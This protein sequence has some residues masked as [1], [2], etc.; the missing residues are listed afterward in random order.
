MNITDTVLVQVNEIESL[1]RKSPN[2]AI[3]RAQTEFSKLITSLNDDEVIKFAQ[4]LVEDKKYFSADRLCRVY[5]EKKPKEIRALHLLAT[6]ATRVGQDGV[7]IDYLLDCLD[8]NPNLAFIHFEL[9]NC[10]FNVSNYFMALK[11][12]EVILTSDSDHVDTLGLKAACLIKL[13]KYD[14]AVVVYERLIGLHSNTAQVFLRYGSVLK[15]VGRKEDAIKAFHQALSINENLGEAYW[16]LANLKTYEFDDE[17]INR[18][19]K[20]L[21]NVDEHSQNFVYLN[22]SLAVALEK[23]GEFPSAFQCLEKANKA[24]KIKHNYQAIKTTEKIEKFRN[25]FTREYFSNN[26]SKNTSAEP[27]F[28]LG[29][30]RSGS[31]LI[32][33]VLS[34]HSQIDATMELSEIGAMVRSLGFVKREGYEQGYPDI[35]KS[36]SSDELTNFGNEYLK[37]TKIFR[38]NA[39]HF[40]DKTPSNFIHI[41]LIKSILP[42]AKIIDTRR[43]LMSCGFSIYKQ[44][45]AEGFLFA[46]SLDDIGGYYNDYL[47][48]MDHWHDVLPGEILTVEYENV[49]N[50]LETQVRR[51][52]DFCDL[53]YEE[54]CL[55]FYKS[56]RAVAT[57]SSEQVRQPIYVNALEYW[58]NYEEFLAPLKLFSKT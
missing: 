58:R 51:I 24:L 26:G 9:A 56:K 55:Q 40:I 6:V 10:F 1:A 36:L 23:Q 45:F 31:T 50:D 3:A 46:N 16:N 14:G 39:I 35:L 21:S 19:R 33:Q 22:F 12:C 8:I 43:D 20:L 7:A 25:F 4:Q 11:Q 29:L 47:T 28:I 32:E 15:T 27:I 42:K 13:G 57:I 44:F 17:S 37:R 48:I 53:E 34:C 54:Q 5:L 18:M 52:L 38:N 30:P 49:V 2:L 41:G